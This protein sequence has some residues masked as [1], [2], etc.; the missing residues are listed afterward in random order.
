[1]RDVA[2]H[3]DEGFRTGA[4]TLALLEPSILLQ[5]VENASGGTLPT[6]LERLAIPISTFTDRPVMNGVDFVVGK[7]SKFIRLHLST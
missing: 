1:M 7:A 3:A 6:L 5:G 2:Q 4:P